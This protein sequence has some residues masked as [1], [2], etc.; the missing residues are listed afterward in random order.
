MKD[1][2][3]QKLRVW[4]P[5]LPRGSDEHDSEA[6]GE[7]SERVGKGVEGHLEEAENTILDIEACG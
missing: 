4:R 1:E 5:D 2:W 7:G 6:R 3:K